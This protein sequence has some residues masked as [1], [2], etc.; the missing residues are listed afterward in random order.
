MNEKR[1]LVLL[2]LMLMLALTIMLELAAHGEGLAEAGAR[3]LTKGQTVVVGPGERVYAPSGVSVLAPNG[4]NVVV[5]GHQNTVNTAAGAV[6]T[7]P[8][9]AEGPADNLIVVGG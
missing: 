4:A 2:A 1:R 9:D 7:V 8:E 3:Q 6:V 5:T